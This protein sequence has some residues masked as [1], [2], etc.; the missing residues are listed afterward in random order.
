MSFNP[1]AIWLVLGSILAGT[2][3][4]MIGAGGGFLMVP[5]MLFLFETTSPAAIAA[6][7]LVAV[8]FNGASSS[9]AYAR[10]RRIDYKLAL[11]LVATT[12][13]GAVLGAWIVKFIPR[14]TFEAVFAAILI[15]VSLFLIVRPRLLAKRKVTSN[16]DETGGTRLVDAKGMVYRYRTSRKFVFPLGLVTGVLSSTLGVGGGIIQVPALVLLSMVPIQVA[17]A[18]SQFILVGTSF[19]GIVSHLALGHFKL[20]W[21]T[22]LMLTI[23]VVIGG[24]VG[25]R[26]AAKIGGRWLTTLL[27]LALM[28]VGVRLLI[29]AF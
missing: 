1:D 19:S 16:P 8:F 2:W 6:A 24:Q 28:V 20:P 5:L 12:I 11:L 25:A 7:S 21:L 15:A 29:V 4:T 10:M 18:T 13:P 22:V 14:Q 9:M 3:G 26:F 27:A 17:A 23:G